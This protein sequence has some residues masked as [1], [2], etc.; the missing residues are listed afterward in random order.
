LAHQWRE[1]R[2][3][4][5]ETGEEVTQALRSTGEE[6]AKSNAVTEK[7]FDQAFWTFRSRFDAEWGGFG[8]AP[9]FPRTHDL[10]FLLRHRLRTG[11]ERIGEIVRVTLDRM[12]QGGIHDHLGGGFH[13]YSVDAHWVVPHFE[14]MMY[15]QALIARTYV[16]AFLALKEPRYGE[17]ARD[18]FDYVLREM[19]LAG[20]GFASAED[21]DS[22]GEEGTFYVWSPR[23]IETVLGKDEGVFFAKSYGVTADGNFE[24]G[25]SVPWLE[26]RLTEEE[27][28]R[29]APLRRKLF[30]A[31]AK[32]PRPL[33][34]DKVLAE[35]NGMMISALARGGSAL[36]ESKYLEAARRAAS[37]VLSEMVREGRLLRRW[38]GG[39]AEIPA[40]LDDYA[41][42]VEA[43]LDL[44]ETTFEGRWLR[45]AKHLA[46]EMVRRFSD[47]ERGGFYFS[48][49]DGEALILRSKESYDGATPSGNSVAALA[50]L[51]LGH[52]L[53]D[54]SFMERG[55]K[56][57]EAFGPAIE[58]ASSSMTWMLCG[59]DFHLS[60]PSEI[61]IAASDPSTAK[62]LAQVLRS[63]FLPHAV[64]ALVS[65]EITEIAPHLGTYKPVDGKP[66]AY[67]CRDFTCERPVTT[68]EELEK[69]L[70]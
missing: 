60:K 35:W 27:D 70:K 14:K 67:V 48:A 13:R 10:M 56:V 1:N 52:L 3:E 5:V 22:E 62:P 38:R 32:R 41:W 51:R 2:K 31:R 69:I 50:L 58:R 19:T 59:L 43:L 29:L 68:A 42:M 4:L 55:A 44:Y 21:A 39:S 65:P 33:R 63:R 49:S 26:N 34:D 28:R 54:E 16:E 6:K 37:F 23:E 11:S 53:K 61:V 12:A 20:G 30:D 66:A 46:E 17:V 57:F 18:I 9:K 45:E 64:V 25:K 15:D 40:F 36:S 47:G 24:H 8:E 7:V